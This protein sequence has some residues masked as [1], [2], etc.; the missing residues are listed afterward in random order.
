MEDMREDGGIEAPCRS[1]H[2]LGRSRWDGRAGAL[3][4]RFWRLPCFRCHASRGGRLRSM[5]LHK[6]VRGLAVDKFTRCDFTV[7]EPIA[8]NAERRSGI[9]R[10]VEQRTAADRSRQCRHTNSRDPPFQRQRA[11][12][13][14]GAVVA[15]GPIPFPQQLAPGE[16]H[17]MAGRVGVSSVAVPCPPRGPRGSMPARSRPRAQN[18]MTAARYRGCLAD[19]PPDNF[20]P[21]RLLE[22]SDGRRARGGRHRTGCCWP[23]G[24]PT[25]LHPRPHLVWRN[26]CSCPR[27]NN[28]WGDFLPRMWPLKRR[29]GG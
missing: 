25:P 7:G 20:R 22:M 10:P 11:K 14:V 5:A 6:V 12:S 3:G 26:P 19:T 2:A 21:Y 24:A 1:G 28:D 13:R 15:Q 4:A 17:P 9:G 27:V 16:A 23:C 8:G 29:Q 18:Q